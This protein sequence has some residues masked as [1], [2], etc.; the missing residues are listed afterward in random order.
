M[1]SA[2]DDSFQGSFICR[3]ITLYEP[4]SPK[5]GASWRVGDR[6]QVSLLSFARSAWR[7]PCDCAQVADWP[8]PKARISPSS[9]T[10]LA[11]FRTFARSN[12]RLQDSYAAL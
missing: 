6:N 1:I 7:R 4:L 5:P 3:S 11:V 9:R 10:D 8:F 12:R 2:S